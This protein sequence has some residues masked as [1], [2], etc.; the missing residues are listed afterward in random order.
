MPWSKLSE[1][2]K[3]LRSLDGVALTL[4]QANQIAS[5]ADA[6]KES[7]KSD[8]S[9]WAIAISQFK[10]GRKIR[11]GSSEEKSFTVIEKQADGSYWI[12]AVSTAALED[13]EGETFGVEA[14]DYDIAQAKEHGDFPEFRVFHSKNL[15]IGK[16]E[17]MTRAGI[18]AVDE[19]RSYTDP[20]S[21]SVCEKMLSK[22]DGRYRCSRGFR[23]IEASGSCPGCETALVV[24]EDHFVTGFKCPVCDTFQSKYKSLGGL[25]YRKARTF[26]VTITDI[27]CVPYTGASAS[28]LN[29]PILE[30]N[31]TKEELKERLLKAGIEEEVIESRLK[32]MDANAMK[33][34]E[35]VPFATVLK[36]FRAE[37]ESDE[38]VEEKEE[39]VFILDPEVLGDF[40][41]IV[42][43]EVAEV[44][45][46][47]TIDIPDDEVLK[48]IP[49]IEELREEVAELKEM[50]AQLLQKDETKLKEMLQDAPRG[51]KLRVYKCASAKKSYKPAPEDEE[52]YEEEDEEDSEDE[53]EFKSLPPWLRKMA[54]EKEA[55]TV[56]M[57]ADGVRAATLTEFIT[58]GNNG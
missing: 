2:P 16:V 28:K 29:N 44:M 4:S 24:K 48:E 54:E 53:K 17:K 20:F 56:I 49:G 36:E 12:T 9:A 42:R 3:N 52:D 6:L 38:E 13:K 43:K 10:K 51:G 14:M 25:K 41:A 7:G 15:G 31:M 34:L 46:G 23:V 19:G 37:E 22:N 21:L 57:G 50:V 32:S 1:V 33:Q 40:T 45:N 5:V 8:S 26:D 30:D 18:F 55:G 58:G 35:D 47:L 11:N 39:Q 27:P